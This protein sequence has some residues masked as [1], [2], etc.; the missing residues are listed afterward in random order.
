MALSFF[1]ALNPISRN[2]GVQFMWQ[3]RYIGDGG[4]IMM[5][6]TKDKFFYE[7]ISDNIASRNLYVNKFE[8]FFYDLIFVYKVLTGHHYGSDCYKGLLD[9]LIFPLIARKLIAD[10]ELDERKE[11]HFANALALTIAI[12]LEIIRITIA[13]A[14]TLVFTP[15]VAIV[16][17]IEACLPQQE[18]SN[19]LPFDECYLID[20]KG[21]ND[22]P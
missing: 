2:S 9:Y 21:V 15:I 12:P 3:N 19:N 8:T 18:Q 6:E 14:L 17:F 5:D 22:G 10:A 1:R 20:T 13:F 11:N 7:F 16:H 4:F